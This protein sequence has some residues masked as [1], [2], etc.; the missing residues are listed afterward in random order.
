MLVGAYEATSDDAL[1]E[2]HEGRI[3]NGAVVAWLV[4]KGGGL[5]GEEIVHFSIDALDRCG[6]VTGGAGSV[7]AFL[8]FIQELKEGVGS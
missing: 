1:P 4:V 6:S 3:L 7:A 5:P 8:A 2:S